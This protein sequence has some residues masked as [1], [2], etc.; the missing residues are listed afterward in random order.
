MNAL[1]GI[2]AY[3]IPVSYTHRVPFVGLIGERAVVDTLHTWVIA[4][5]ASQNGSKKAHDKAEMLW[6][7]R[8]APAITAGKRVFC[9][10]LNFAQDSLWMT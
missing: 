7:Q 3:P 2:Y 9:R 8:H 6:Q 1:H 5:E 4:V 10:L